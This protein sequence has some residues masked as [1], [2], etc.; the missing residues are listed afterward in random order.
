MNI[1]LTQAA[2][3]FTPFHNRTSRACRTNSWYRWSGYTVVAEYSMAQQF[4]FRR[5]PKISSKAVIFLKA[6]LSYTDL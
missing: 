6:Y 2:L 4:F 1:D 3:K 5:G